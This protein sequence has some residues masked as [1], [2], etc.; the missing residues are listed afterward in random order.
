VT[1]GPGAPVVKAPL[2]AIAA[3]SSVI[4]IFVSGF[5]GSVL[6]FPVWRVVGHEVSCFSLRDTC[7]S[8]SESVSLKDLKD[9]HSRET[10]AI[11]KALSRG[12]CI[13]STTSVRL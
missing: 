8:Q 12:A 5:G 7:G 2:I 4:L 3:A 6:A 13:T 1:T 9:G 11:P 10:T